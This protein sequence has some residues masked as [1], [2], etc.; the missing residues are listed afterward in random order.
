VMIID[1]EDRD[2]LAGGA[3]GFG[4]DGGVVEVA[5]A[6]QIIGAAMVAG[7]TAQGEGVALAR[8]HRLRRR[9]GGLRPP[10]SAVPGAGTDRRG[11]VIA[12]AAEQ[13]STRV[14]SSGRR[15]TTG[16]E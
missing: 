4:G 7:R 2:A 6:A 16:Q 10:I 13:A 12:V 14:R 8:Q 9:E 3:G 5:I 15:R 1:V 11:G